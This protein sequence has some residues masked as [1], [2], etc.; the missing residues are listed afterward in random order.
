[1]GSPSGYPENTN[2]VLAWTSYKIVNAT[3]G[4]Y[5]RHVTKAV[6]GTLATSRTVETVRTIKFG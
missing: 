6:D 2:I 1:M 5:A 3:T 4:G